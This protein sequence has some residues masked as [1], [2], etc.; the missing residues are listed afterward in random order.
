MQI[1]ISMVEIEVRRAIADYIALHY[2]VHVNP[3]DLVIEV[4]SKQ[5]YKSEWENAAI[6][7]ETTARPV[8]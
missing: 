7:L 5:N 6:R 4:K 3:D 8:E 1:K 2:G